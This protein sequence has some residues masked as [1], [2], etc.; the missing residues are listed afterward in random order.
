MTPVFLHINSS[1]GRY[2]RA[3]LCEY[4]NNAF[5]VH[6]VNPALYTHLDRIRRDKIIRFWRYLDVRGIANGEEILKIDNTSSVLALEVE[7]KEYFT[8]LRNPVDRYLSELSHL[9]N[10]IGAI[11]NKLSYNIMVKSL[12]MALT[13]SVEYY[14][15]EITEKTYSMVVDNLSDMCV[16]MMDYNDS[17]YNR[18]NDKFKFNS[19]VDFGA[20]QRRD[21]SADLERKIMKINKW[22]IKLYE[23]FKFKD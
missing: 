13:G 3:K 14:F 8:V 2:L 15:R 19:P 22:D 20:Y 4:Y 11:D 18:L 5:Y 9:P 21:I 10:D 23:H 17:S 6:H 7:D 12:L 16:I 1:G